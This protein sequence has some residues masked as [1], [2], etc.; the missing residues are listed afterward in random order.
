[1]ERKRFINI[2]AAFGITV[3]L[4]LMLFAAHF[5]I[6]INAVKKAV[7]VISVKVF[8]GSTG[9]VDYRKSTVIFRAEE[10]ELFRKLELS[11]DILFKFS[12]SFFEL[13]WHINVQEITLTNAAWDL[14]LQQ[15]KLNGQDWN[16]LSDRIFA[17]LSF[18][19]YGEKKFPDFITRGNLLLTLCI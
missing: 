7:S 6:R 16:K 17:G 11:G 12:S 18:F 3:F 5:I 10:S 15:K 4:L 2:A 13:P 19:E 9:V 14:N 8:N 1:M